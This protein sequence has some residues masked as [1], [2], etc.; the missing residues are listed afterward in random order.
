MEERLENLKV[1]AEI[2]IEAKY[3][4]V[5][6]QQEARAEIAQQVLDQEMEQVK[7]ERDKALDSLEY[8]RAQQHAPVKGGR[9]LI[10]RPM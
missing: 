5:C 3:G 7:R 10:A 1:Y 9:H 8:T 4:E 2:N 6:E